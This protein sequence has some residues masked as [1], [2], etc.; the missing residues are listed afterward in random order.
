MN[1]HISKTLFAATFGTFVSL[2]AGPAQAQ[3]HGLADLTFKIKVKVEGNV[4][5]ITSGIDARCSIHTVSAVHGDITRVQT[6]N[7]LPPGQM[8]SPQT[9][10]GFIEVD[11]TLK[12]WAYWEHRSDGTLVEHP[13]YCDVYPAQQGASPGFTAP[14]APF[15]AIAPADTGTC[16]RALGVV[17]SDGSQKD[18]EH[19]CASR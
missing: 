9:P 14:T 10:D 18:I 11:V 5:A 12:D 8:F 4:A 1:F 16:S 19:R 17:S 2:S 6:V 13:W 3:N 7:I 15:A